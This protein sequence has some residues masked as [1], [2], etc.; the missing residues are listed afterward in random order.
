MSKSK[1]SFTLDENEREDYIAKALF[2]RN[3]CVYIGL[4]RIYSTATSDRVYT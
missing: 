2:T 3:I 4:K 1:G